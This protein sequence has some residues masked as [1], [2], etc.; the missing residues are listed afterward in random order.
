MY[1]ND[2]Y[3]MDDGDQGSMLRSR[4]RYQKELEDWLNQSGVQRKR[5]K[6]GKGRG[7]GMLI[8]L[9]RRRASSCHLIALYL[10]GLEGGSISNG[11]CLHRE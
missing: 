2:G 3:E 4:P 9:G 7:E 11:Q 8:Y 5:R 1:R 10:A 6:S